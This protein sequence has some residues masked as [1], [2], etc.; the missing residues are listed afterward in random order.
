MCVL[1]RSS[2][3]KVNRGFSLLSVNQ[4]EAALA[5]F[6][7][8]IKLDETFGAAFL[9]RGQV[10]LQL[11][12]IDQAV[13]NF[14]QAMQL[15][16]ILIISSPYDPSWRL[17]R[18]QA[19]RYLAGYT[20]RPGSESQLYHMRRA[21]K[22]IGEALKLNPKLA[23]ALIEQACEFVELQRFDEAREN[24]RKALEHSPTS[25]PTCLL[26]PVCLRLHQHSHTMAVVPES[27]EIIK[28][29]QEIQGRYARLA[30]VPSVGDGATSAAII[31][32]VESMLAWAR[33]T[34]H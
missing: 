23:P 6:S 24:L 30:L 8:A 10:Y 7:T 3:I 29:L 1:T 4:L 27:T 14:N 22:D 13:H 18:A 21:L 26:I 34:A 19:H 33:E 5:D 11:N 17:Y 32:A 28:N 12:D 25:T 9:G 2:W 16:S 15:L 20:T 31:A